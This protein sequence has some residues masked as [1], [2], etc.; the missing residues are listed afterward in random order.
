MNDTGTIRKVFMNTTQWYM[1]MGYGTTLRRI[2]DGFEKMDYWLGTKG[3]QTG[4]HWEWAKG[5]I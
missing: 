1:V 5:T 2:I 3:H 4:N